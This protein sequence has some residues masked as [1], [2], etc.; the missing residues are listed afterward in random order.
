MQKVCKPAPVE[1]DLE[2]DTATD[3]KELLTFVE[4]MQTLYIKSDGITQMIK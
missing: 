2:F 4:Q 3:N 1:I